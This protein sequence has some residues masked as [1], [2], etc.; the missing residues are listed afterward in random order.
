MWAYRGDGTGVVHTEKS[1]LAV[2]L[3]RIGC[4]PA[5]RLYGKQCKMGRVD[6]AG[7]RSAC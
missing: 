5:A 2:F 1:C 4:L 7:A 6:F 3:L